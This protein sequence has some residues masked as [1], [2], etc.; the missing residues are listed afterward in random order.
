MF[1]T[2]LPGTEATLKLIRDGNA[3]TVTATLGEIPGEV[4]QN[5]NVRNNSNASQFG[6]RRA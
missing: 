2:A 1:P 5:T 4:A 3:K 6:N